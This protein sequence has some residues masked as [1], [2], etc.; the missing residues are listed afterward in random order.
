MAELNQASVSRTGRSSRS[1]K[2]LPKVDLTAMVDLAFL[3]ITFFMLTTTLSKPSAMELAMPVDGPPS[4]I[5][6]NRTLS[7][8]LGDRD[9]LLC[10]RGMADAPVDLQ[11]IKP[12]RLR[13]LLLQQKRIVH[14]EAAKPLMVLIK[15]SEVSN[16]ESLV[17]VLD[18]MAIV[19]VVSYA[20]VDLANSEKRLM[21]Q[22]NSL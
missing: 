11:V 4:A 7:I 19:Q 15:P 21:I 1:L 22:R 6:G 12:V 16:Y 3:L 10:Y 13:A 18:E 20:I 14:Q 17:N 8:C 9:Q 2:T 5:A